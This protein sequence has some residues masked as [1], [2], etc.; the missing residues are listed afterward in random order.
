MIGES[1][2]IT[3]VEIRG[4]KVRVGIEAPPGVPVHREDVYRAIKEDERRGVGDIATANPEVL[5]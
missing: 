1:V 5:P 2:I 3:L 4:D